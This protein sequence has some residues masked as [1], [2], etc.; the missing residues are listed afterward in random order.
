M[1][2]C[3]EADEGVRDLM[4]YTLNMAGCDAAGFATVR[5]IGYRLEN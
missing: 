1:I 3:L 2:F 4:I 5:G